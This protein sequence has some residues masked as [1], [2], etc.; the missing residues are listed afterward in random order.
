MLPSWTDTERGRRLPGAGEGVRRRRRPGHADRAGPRRR[1]PR[2]SPPR[3]ARRR[4]RSAT[5]RSSASGTSSAAGTS[6]CRSSATP[7]ATWWPSATASARSSAGTRRSSRRRRRRPSPERL[8]DGAARGRGGRRPRGGLRG[9]GHGRVP[10]RPGRR[11]LL[12]GDEHPAPGRAPG[13]RVRAPVSTWCGCNCSSPRASRCRSAAPPPARGHAIEVRLCAEDPACGLAAVDRDAAPLQ[14]CRG[15]DRVRPAGRAGSAARLGRG[16]RLGGRRALRLDARQ[17]DRLGADPRR[18]GPAA[19]QRAGPGRAAR[20]DHQPGPAGPGAAQPGVR[21]RWRS[22]PV[23]WTGTRRS[24]PRCCPAGPAS[25]VLPRRRAGGRRAPPARPRRCSPGS[26]PAGATCP[27]SLRSPLRRAGRRR[28]RD[29]LPPGPRP[30]G[31]PTGPAPRRPRMPPS[32]RHVDPRVA[33]VEATPDR[34]VLDVDGVRRAYRVHRVGVGGLRGRPGRGGE[35]DRAAAP[36]AARD[37]GGRRFAARA[38]ARRGDRV[39]VRVGQRVA[40]GEPLLTLEAMK[41]EHPVLAPADGVV[42]ELPV[43]TG[44]QVQAGAVLA[45]IDGS[46]APGELEP[47][48]PE[49]DP[50]DL[51]PHPRAGPAARRR[52]RRWAAATATATSSRRRRPAS[53]PPSC[54]PRRTARLPGRQHPHRVRRRGRRHHRAGD[55]LRGAGGRRLPAAAAGGLAGHRGDRARQARHR[56][57]AQAAPARASPT[58]PRRSSS[59]S[60]NRRPVPTS[61]GSAR[62]PAATATAGCSTAASATSP[63]STRPVTCW[64]WRGPSD[65]ADRQAEAGAVPGADRRAPG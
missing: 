44:G 7:T 49:E 39:L 43:P 36:P 65:S 41:L 19:G 29:P 2:R 5:A 42:A 20:R 46:P 33:L 64:W 14:R 52:A 3:A 26:P 54:G 22:T 11:V 15:R 10:A 48:N 62:W 47:S 35:P 40:A 57:A 17:A 27:P 16:G 34:V 53:T 24:S 21:R 4:P 38:A 12:P 51:R 58:A 28:D 60:P 6:R 31:S 37:G 1:W 32:G 9:R 45:V 55:R 25:A 50:D 23:S 56:G 61:T 13:H 59:R 8:R 63:A 18:G 30:D